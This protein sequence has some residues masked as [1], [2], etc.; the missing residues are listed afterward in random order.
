[1]SK[2]EKV[3]AEIFVAAGKYILEGGN[4]PKLVGDYSQAKII[5]RATLASRRLYEALC[6]ENASIDAIAVMVDEKRRAEREFQSAF[7]QEWR[8]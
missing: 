6:D 2:E 8:L 7:G 1:M 3:L 4:P 5:R